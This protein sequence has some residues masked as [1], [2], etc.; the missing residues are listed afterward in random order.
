MFKWVGPI[1][2]TSVAVF[3]KTGLGTLSRKQLLDEIKKGVKLLGFGT[4][5]VAFAG[6]L[7]SEC[8]DKIAV[9]LL[10]RRTHYPLDKTNP[11]NVEIEMLQKL[12]HL[13]LKR[14]TPHLNYLHYNMECPAEIVVGETKTGLPSK[15]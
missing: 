15:T 5:G 14:R 3:G 9:K 11:S 12:N 1:A 6:C 8:S 10:K 13:I 4:N 2:D 7:D